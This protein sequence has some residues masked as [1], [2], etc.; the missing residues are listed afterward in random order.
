MS[1]SV[2]WALKNGILDAM[3]GVDADD[4]GLVVISYLTF[5]F[6]LLFTRPFYCWRAYLD[7]SKVP[8]EWR[9]ATPDKKVAEAGEGLI[10]CLKNTAMTK[11]Q[12]L[13][14]RII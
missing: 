3:K 8:E 7:G 6:P 5:Y 12:L 11:T 10:E 9:D 13:S 14:S 4:S 2:R 1:K